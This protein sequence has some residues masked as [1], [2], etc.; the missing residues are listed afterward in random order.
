[1]SILIFNFHEGISMLV[2]Y[3]FKQVDDILPM[4]N[5]HKVMIL[6]E[7]TMYFPHLDY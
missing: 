7:E 1:M 6:K 3:V 2:D 4:I 5:D